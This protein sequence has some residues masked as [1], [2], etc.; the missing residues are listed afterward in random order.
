MNIIK[1]VKIRYLTPIPKPYAI[2]AHGDELPASRF[3]RIFFPV[4][5]K[6]HNDLAITSF[7]Y[8]INSNRSLFGLGPEEPKWFILRKRTK[9]TTPSCGLK[10]PTLW[11]KFWGT[12]SVLTATESPCCSSC[13]VFLHER[14]GYS[15]SIQH[16]PRL[17][18]KEIWFK[19]TSITWWRRTKLK[20]KTI[21]R[22]C[23]WS[24]VRTKKLD[25]ASDFTVIS[26]TSQYRIQ[27]LSVY[28]PIIRTREEMFTSL[29]IPMRFTW[30]NLLCKDSEYN[31]QSSFIQNLYVINEHSA[32][33]EG[34][35]RPVLV[36]KHKVT[37][38]SAELVEG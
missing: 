34:N 3:G 31:L 28:R 10:L 26:E 25:A 4:R 32:S 15:S 7:C 29:F 12:S 24:R 38:N 23:W 9:M 17:H 20:L 14:P 27:P 2:T 16:V 22:K 19:L 37:S 35:L 13:L 18:L 11:I 6:T 33:W 8:K 1:G 30:R 5:S 21:A 36:L